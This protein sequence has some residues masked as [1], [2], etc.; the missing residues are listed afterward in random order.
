LSTARQQDALGDQREIAQPD[1]QEHQEY[2]E[3]HPSTISGSTS[4]ESIS[5]ENRSFPNC[6]R[7]ST[8]AA[9]VPSIALSEAAETATIRLF[10]SVANIAVLQQLPYQLKENPSRSP[11]S[12][13]LNEYDQDDDRQEQE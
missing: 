4:G 1:V 2:Q 3:R 13:W 8:S 12:A 5:V 6:C 11:M 9:I 10:F 7:T